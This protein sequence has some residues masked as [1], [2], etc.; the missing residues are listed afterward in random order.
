MMFVH[1][2]SV[3]RP[4]RA[5]FLGAGCSCVEHLSAG[6]FPS[7]SVSV[8]ATSLCVKPVCSNSKWRTKL[9]GIKCLGYA[10]TEIPGAGCLCAEY[11]RTGF[12]FCR[13]LVC[14]I[15]VCGNLGCGMLVCGMP[16]A[17]S[18]YAGSDCA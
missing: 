4:S 1:G 14:R 3:S 16:C 9:R 7:R 5:R 15:F 2:I 11:P 12:S 18:V 17:R 6:C 10:V 13:M 8:C